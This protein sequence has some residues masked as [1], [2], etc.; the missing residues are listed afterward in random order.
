MESGGP[1]PRSIEADRFKDESMSRFQSRE[2]VGVGRFVLPLF[3]AAILLWSAPIQG[4]E[5]TPASKSPSAATRKVIGY[6]LDAEGRPVAGATVCLTRVPNSED[7]F[8]DSVVIA[9]TQSQSE[10]RFKLTALE[11]DVKKAMADPPAVFEIWIHK[12]GLALAHCYIFGEAY[13]EPQILS[14]TK[15]SPTT[16]CLRKPDGAPC[17]D[18]TVTPICLWQP[19]GRWSPAIPKLIQDELKTRSTADGRVTVAG[20]TGQLAILAIETT[21]FGQQKV[22]IPPQQDPP[23]AVT[24]RESQSVEGRL[25]LPKAEKVDLS[26]LAVTISEISTE[27]GPDAKMTRRQEQD[28][29]LAPGT[30]CASVL[31]RS[32]RDGHFSIAR[33]PKIEHGSMYF[34]LWGSDEIPITKEPSDSPPSLTLLAGGRVELD[35]PLRKGRWVTWIVRD[36]R[37][38]R[39]LAGIDAEIVSSKQS[40]LEDTSDENGLFRVCLCPGETYQMHCQLRDG[41]LR[42]APGAEDDIVIPPGAEQLELKP[43]ELVPGVAVQGEVLDVAGQHLAGI[44]VR[45]TWRA[46][47]PPT[48]KGQAAEVSRWTT[49]DAEG[50]FQFEGVESGT[51]VT[52]VPVRAGIPLADPVQIAASRDKPVRLQEKKDERTALSG[53]ILG[54]DHKPIAGAQIVVEV[55]HS[56]DPTRTFRTAVDADGSFQTP[57]NFPKNLKY[58]LTVRAILKDVASSAW[59][60][61]AASGSRLP[62]LVVERS[63]LGLDTR[64]SG[65]EI[66]A[67]VDGR[68]ILASEFFE[69]AYPEPL[70]PDGLSLQVAAK[71]ALSGGVTEREFRTLQETAIKKYVGDYIR[72]RMLSWA[73]EATL[74]KVRK[75]QL[76]QTIAKMFEE[77]VERL[78]KDLKTSKRAD[79]EKRLHAQGASLASFEAEF[80]D[81]LLANE[82]TRRAAPSASDLDWQR[83]L[84]YYQ[85]HRQKYPV[86]E[87]VSWQLLE[88][89]F[90]DPSNRVPKTEAVTAYDDELSRWYKTRQVG[91]QPHPWA[92]DQTRLAGA[93]SPTSDVPAKKTDQEF[94]VLKYAAELHSHVSR[95]KA[96]QTLDTV[97]ACEWM[98]MPFE[99]II[100]KFSTGSNA[101]KGGWQPR[102]RPDSLADEQTAA[103]LRQLPEGA[104]SGVIETDHSFRIVRVACRTPAGYQPFEEVED[105]IRDHIRQELQTKALEEIYSRTAIESPYIDDVSSILHRTAACCPPKAKDDAFAP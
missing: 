22:V 81:C 5:P 55:E 43:I 51:N 85:A 58:R 86:R 15:E 28:G 26:K 84:A 72:K 62:D 79:V 59:I 65:S 66:V 1:R 57:A 27:T 95:Q 19:A 47:D 78:K 10:G 89:E 35:I 36:A 77:Y 33:F 68:P 45:G 7:E 64:Y 29:A 100:K 14:M 20:L 54:T 80:R 91:A 46:G 63:K 50:H 93:T 21:E 30:L 52:L 24:L 102:V 13:K 94:E 101:D 8:E 76:E 82:Y 105:L 92:A 74:D 48:G 73:Y 40:S 42:A 90:D 12:A 70:P 34:H 6:A 53:R 61:P 17:R 87:K 60:C 18:A 71:K 4:K 39:P 103:A 96:R 99:K 23:F 104:T 3:A 11:A 9:Q 25:V 98:G 16:I 41:Y 67:I 97:I 38:K 31:V 44:R 49:T 32:D 2:R 37:T 88:I 75:D 83:V 56:L 69:R